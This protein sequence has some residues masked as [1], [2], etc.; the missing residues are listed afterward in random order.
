M[1]AVRVFTTTYCGWCHRAKA[2]LAE[3][4]VDFEEIDV[5]DDAERR[6]RLIEA[7]GGRRTVPVIFADDRCLG[8]FDEL[9]ELDR[10]GALTAALGG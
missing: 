6:A 9:L 10:T 8:G 4:G 5:T 1:P 7:S 2:L 3:R